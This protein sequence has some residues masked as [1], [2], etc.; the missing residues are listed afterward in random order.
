MPHQCV[1]CGKLIEDGSKE[2]LKGCN[3]CSGKLFFFLKKS[4]IEELKKS[5]SIPDL[6]E[7]DKKQIEKDV[8]DLIGPEYN[9]D[10]P[11]VLN[12]ESIRVSKPGKFELD[13]VSLF[14]SKKP[15]VYK[16]EEGKYMI[17]VAT[18]FE[19]ATKGSKRAKKITRKNL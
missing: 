18:T 2:I 9:D 11:V 6:S 15:L 17:D 4:K 8:S 10:S 14:D 16:L 13:L 19:H 1:R 12:F 5:D 7:K 3:S